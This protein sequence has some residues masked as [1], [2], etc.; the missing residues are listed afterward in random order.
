MSLKRVSQDCLSLASDVGV[1]RMAHRWCDIWDTLANTRT[2]VEPSGARMTF[3]YDVQ[4]HTVIQFRRV[5]ISSAISS[6]AG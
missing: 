1:S 4:S 5:F 2:V 6:G 3:I